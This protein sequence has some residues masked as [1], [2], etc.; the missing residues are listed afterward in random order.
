MFDSVLY[1]LVHIPSVIESAP[2]LP[3]NAEVNKKKII[4]YLYKNQKSIILF[5]FFN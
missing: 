5:C 4:I 3:D 1:T 2:N